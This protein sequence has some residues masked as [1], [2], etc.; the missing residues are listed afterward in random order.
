MSATA[1][2][3]TVIINNFNV[4]EAIVPITLAG[5]Y[6]GTAAGDTLSFLGIVPSNSVPI[7]VDIKEAPAA[8][9][10]PSGIV[11]NFA[12]GTMQAN[13][14]LQALIPAGGTPAGTIVSTST[15]PTI[16]TSSG[17]VSTALGVAAG[18][19]SEVTGASGIT[20]VQAPTITSTFTGSAGTAGELTN[21]GN[22]TYASV[23][24]ANLV[25]RVVFKK[26]V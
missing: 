13:G 26:F 20:G 8:G 18:A 7:F 4:F 19:L 23:S 11:W 3:P 5:S 10:L 14:S 17:G 21:L 24:A 15:A 22:V 12:P 16:T 1:G 9:T 2:T 25:A 6:P